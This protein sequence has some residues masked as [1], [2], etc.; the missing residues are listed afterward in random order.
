MK[1]VDK[2]VSG[3]KRGEAVNIKHGR[4]QTLVEPWMGC[5][6]AA[7]RPEGSCERKLLIS[8][9]GRQFLI[10]GKTVRW[11]RGITTLCIV[12]GRS[13]LISSTGGKSGQLGLPLKVTTICSTPKRRRPICVS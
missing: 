4:Y 8:K 1:H 7:M 13:R 10:T 6:A 12:G 3:G 9:T 5:I 2:N 11:K